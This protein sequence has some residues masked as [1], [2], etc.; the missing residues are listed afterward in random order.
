MS[1]TR[2]PWLRAIACDPS[3]LPL[4]A[5][6]ISPATALFA[7]NARAFERQRPIVSASLRQ[8]MTIDS[9]I[10]ADI[11]ASG[12]GDNEKD[13]HSGFYPKVRRGPDCPGTGYTR[14]LFMA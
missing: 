1:T 12:K 5:T 7:R 14:P 13:I 8:G 11:R 9:S 2:A 10:R 6:M 4:S 3:V